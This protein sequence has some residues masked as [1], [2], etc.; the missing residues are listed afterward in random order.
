MAELTLGRT[1]TG[2]TEVGPDKKPV[3]WKYFGNPD[4]VTGLGTG[5]FGPNISEGIELFPLL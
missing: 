4:Q 5:V 1:L 2:S 3:A